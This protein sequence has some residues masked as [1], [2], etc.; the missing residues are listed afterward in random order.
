[1]LNGYTSGSVS[2]RANFGMSIQLSAQ[3]WKPVVA[4]PRVA[5][6]G[7]DGS[8]YHIV[9]T[10]RILCGILLRFGVWVALFIF[11]FT[12]DLIFVSASVV[13]GVC[14]CVSGGCGCGCGCM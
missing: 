6:S 11:D 14:V 13:Y 12:F 5:Q 2:S 4:T 7:H 8:R 1:M 3:I 10:I 9:F